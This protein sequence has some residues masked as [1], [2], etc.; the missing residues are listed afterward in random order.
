[1]P[2]VVL[3]DQEYFNPPRQVASVGAKDKISWVAPPHLILPVIVP[4]ARGK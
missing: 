4:P 3:L 1:M 2:M